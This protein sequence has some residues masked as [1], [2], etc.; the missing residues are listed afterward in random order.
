MLIVARIEN[1]FAVCE[2]DDGSFVDLPLDR[3]SGTVREGDVL[4][5]SG[6]GYRVDEAETT[7]RRERAKRLSDDLFR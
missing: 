1:G 3:C 6:E 2:Q 4:V 5:Y 7:K